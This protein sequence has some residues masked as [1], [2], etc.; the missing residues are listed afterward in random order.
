MISV[1]MYADMC[2]CCSPPQHT[3]TLTEGHLFP[4]YHPPKDQERREVEHLDSL[5][6]SGV[7]ESMQSGRGPEGVPPNCQSICYA[8]PIAEQVGAVACLHTTQD[9]ADTQVHDTLQ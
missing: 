8:R 9:V 4:V 7:D 3:L 6:A 2:A 1:R 5:L